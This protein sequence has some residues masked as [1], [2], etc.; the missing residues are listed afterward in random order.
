M[1]S[2]RCATSTWSMTPAF[3]SCCAPGFAPGTPAGTRRPG[4]DTGSGRRPS[5]AV[6]HGLVAAAQARYRGAARPHRR[7]SAARA[8][9]PRTVP[10]WPTSTLRCGAPSVCRQPHRHR[11]PAGERGTLGRPE[12]ATVVLQRLSRPELDVDG[13]PC[14]RRGRLS[15]RQLTSSRSKRPVRCGCWTRV[16]PGWSTQ[17]ARSSSTTPAGCSGPTSVAS[18]SAAPNARPPWPTCSG[19]P[20]ASEVAEGRV[21]AGGVVAEVPGAV[22][23]ASAAGAAAL[24]RA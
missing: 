24:D 5:R 1:T 20:L 6:V 13:P 9:R 16:A 2:L 17:K 7:R 21:G 19:V 22:T 15:L 23:G 8:A 18:W 10:G 12:L 11:W 3:Q 14:C 4:A